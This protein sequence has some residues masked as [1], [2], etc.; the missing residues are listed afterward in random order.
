MDYLHQ[1][2]EI[3]P[4]G[5]CISSPPLIY[6]FSY[7][8]QYGLRGIYFIL[9]VI[10]Q[11]CF[12][13]VVL[14]IVLALSIGSFFQLASMSFLDMLSF[15]YLFVSY[16]W[17]SFLLSGTTRWPMLIVYISYPGHRISH[18]SKDTWFL[19]LANATRNEGLCATCALCHRGVVTS[20]LT[21]ARK[22]M[23]I[24]Q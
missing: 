21:Q 6:L 13:Y 24:S 3:P 5:S 15:V 7:Q 12:I 16:F 18:F 23:G 22:C 17:S 2:F 11:Y 8:Y 10:I 19:L 20:Q 14:H 4:H 9:W 1:L